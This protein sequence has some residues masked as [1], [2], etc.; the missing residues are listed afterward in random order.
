MATIDQVL[1]DVYGVNVFSSPPITLVWA[2]EYMAQC[3]GIEIAKAELS[4]AN[5][6]REKA[7][8][9]PAYVDFGHP[10]F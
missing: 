4:A 5:L 10:L 8:K 7:G 1:Q 9:R 2:A 6:R 3:N